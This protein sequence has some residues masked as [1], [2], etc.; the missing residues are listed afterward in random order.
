MSLYWITLKSKNKNE[1]DFSSFCE[2]EDMEEAVEYF[3]NYLKFVH[4]SKDEIKK[5]LKKETKNGKQKEE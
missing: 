4:F 3:Y 1:N 5:N 2:A